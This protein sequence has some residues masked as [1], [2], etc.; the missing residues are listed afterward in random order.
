MTSGPAI[1][2]SSGH[3]ARRSMLARGLALLDAFGTSGA[4]LTLAELARRTRLPKPTAHRL[5]AELV[6]WGGLERA[7]NTLRLG[8]RMVALG[9]LAPRERRLREV[10]DPYLAELRESARHSVHLGIFTSTGPSVLVLTRLLSRGAGPAA[11]ACSPVLPAHCTAIGRALLA[12]GSAAQL[13]QVVGRGL[14]RHTGRTVTSPAG[15]LA[16]LAVVQRSGVA[17]CADELV[18]GVTGVAAP[19]F[20]GRPDHGTNGSPD[21]HSHALSAIA[22]CGRSGHIDVRRVAPVLREVCAELSAELRTELPGRRGG[23]GTPAVRP[24]RRF[25]D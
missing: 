22:V 14:R 11:L 20:A 9:W 8:R 19:V 23:R 5:V 4:E 1:T 25:R 12:F 24:P 18:N 6:E 3:G 16:R 21:A 2:G 13:D 15:L 17:V 7:G 10:A